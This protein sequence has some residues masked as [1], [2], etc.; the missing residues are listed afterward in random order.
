MTDAAPLSA[1]GGN[2]RKSIT[3]R[4]AILY[5]FGIIVVVGLVVF[6]Q[7]GAR[8]LPKLEEIANQS[9]RPQIE[10]VTR[11]DSPG[12]LRYFGTGRIKAELGGDTADL[13]ALGEKKKEELQKELAPCHSATFELKEGAFDEAKNIAVI[14]GFLVKGDQRTSVEYALEQD[15][16][17]W[18]VTRLNLK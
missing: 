10:A 8:E 17:V 6:I 3:I 5:G 11:G 1:G 15:D 12:A 7:I 2:Q 9:I 4:R 14:R 16:G 18:R 13:S